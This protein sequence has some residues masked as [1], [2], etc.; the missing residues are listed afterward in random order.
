VRVFPVVQAKW[1][2]LRQREL[3]NLPMAVSLKVAA[4]EFEPRQ[5]DSNNVYLFCSA[6]Q[7]WMYSGMTSISELGNWDGSWLC[8][9]LVGYLKWRGH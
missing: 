8:Y 5:S 2:K 6:V 9:L 1:R 4:P 7:W 3:R